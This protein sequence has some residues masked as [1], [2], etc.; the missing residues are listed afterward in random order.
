MQLDALNDMLGKYMLS[1]HKKV[2]MLANSEFLDLVKLVDG[3]QKEMFVQYMAK[4][5]IFSF[6][7]VFAVLFAILAVKDYK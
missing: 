2:D 3:E 7:G 4:L 5:N 1:V 6:R